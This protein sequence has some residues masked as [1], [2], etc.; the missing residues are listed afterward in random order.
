MCP[1]LLHQFSPLT[2]INYTAIC[3]PLLLHPINSKNLLP[4]LQNIRHRPYRRN[5]KLINLAMT[6]RIMLLDVLKFRRV[7][8]PIN[9][10][11]QMTQPLMQSRVA[12]ANVADVAL[13][14][15]DVDGVEAHDSGVQADVGFGDGGRGEEVGRGSGAKV[16]FET[17][18][19]F[20][21]LSDGFGVGFFGAAGLSVRDP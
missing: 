20:E 15:L 8:E 21:E 1:M 2:S 4:L 17:I 7:L 16:L 5:R 18:E 19:R 10:P 11:V 6:L 9:I 12:G 3:T 13:E 14:V